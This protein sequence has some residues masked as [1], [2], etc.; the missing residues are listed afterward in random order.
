M[1]RW[2]DKVK[3]NREDKIEGRYKCVKVRENMGRERRDR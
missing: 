2:G 3:R 1:E